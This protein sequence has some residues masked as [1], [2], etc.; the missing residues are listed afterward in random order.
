M[1][2]GSGF[3]AG[4]LVRCQ[5]AQMRKSFIGRVHRVF[6]DRL[7]VEVM[8]FHFH[9]R[10]VVEQN[11]YKMVVEANDAKAMPIISCQRGKG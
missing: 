8:N 6:G 11:Q 2:E 5:H 9:D 4:R 10:R 1:S 7:V 3:V